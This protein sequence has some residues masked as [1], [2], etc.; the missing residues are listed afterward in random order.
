LIVAVRGHTRTS[1][2]KIPRAWVVLSLAG[3]RRGSATI[4][5]LDELSQRN[6]AKQEWLRGGFEGGMRCLLFREVDVNG[7]GLE[8]LDTKVTHRKGVKEDLTRH[9]RRE[10]EDWNYG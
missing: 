6:L 3:K 7:Y 1:D 5:A 8:S 9:V 4:K 10:E 2:K